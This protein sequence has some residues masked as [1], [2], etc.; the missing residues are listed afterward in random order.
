MSESGST[1]DLTGRDTLTV[2]RDG[3]QI[4]VYNHVSVSRHHYVNSVNGYEEFKASLTKGDM[5][6][7]PEP[8]AVTDRLARLLWGEFGITVEDRGID[9]IDPADDEVTVL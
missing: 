9:V 1:I 3:E 6:E 4:E 5:A 2:E 7:G 8:E